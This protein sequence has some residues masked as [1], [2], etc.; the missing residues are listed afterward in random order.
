M[1]QTAWYHASSLVPIYLCWGPGGNVVH[2]YP[3]CKLL[4]LYGTFVCIRDS[5][6]NVLKRLLRSLLGYSCCW[7]GERPA[8]VALQLQKLTV[9]H[10][11]VNISLRGFA[12]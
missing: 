9:I 3:V 6:K 1:T 12:S 10:S 11:G 7:C 5:S 8:S 4:T 2:M